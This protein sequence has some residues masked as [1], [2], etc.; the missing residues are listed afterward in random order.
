MNKYV[1]IL[2]TKPQDDYSDFEYDSPVWETFTHAFVSIK[3]MS[4]RELATA[5]EVHSTSTHKII[6]RY[7]PGVTSNMKILA[8][9]KTYEIVAVVEDDS[10]RDMMILAKVIGDG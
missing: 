6:M 3:A 10:G 5:I 1:E 2:R 8:A 4:G 7:Q 9:S